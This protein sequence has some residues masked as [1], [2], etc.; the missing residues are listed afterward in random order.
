METRCH[1]HEEEFPVAPETLF[2]ILHTPT[3]I[4]GWWGASR[5]IVLA[6]K[7]G[8]WAASWGDEDEPD[9][10]ST[11]T[12]EEFEPPRRILFTGGKYFAKTGSPPFEMKMTTEFVVEPR[13]PGC[14]L[15]VI[16]D[17]FPAGEI[18]DDF[19]A[20]CD[21]GWR[22]TFGGIRKYLSK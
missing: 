16:Q 7:G 8:T 14:I 10:I 3:A 18:A 21:T 12:I 19:H 5:S 11:F 22:N 1:I 15:R 13:G 17:G 2:A 4:C 6:E 20:A 9:Y